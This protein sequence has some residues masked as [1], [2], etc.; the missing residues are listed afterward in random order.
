MAAAGII[1]ASML[2]DGISGDIIFET[3][4]LP[5]SNPI[6]IIRTDTNRPDI[7]SI[8]PCPNGWSVS[9]FLSAIIKPAS[10]ITDEP[11]SERLLNASAIIEIAPLML[12]A[13]NFP[14]KR[15]TFNT[16]PVI[17]VKVPYFFLTVPSE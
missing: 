17:P 14:I 5:S 9:G 11:A 4:V 7:Y 15:N 1:T 6:I 16:I 8:L 13:I 2:S 12:P 3:D 10:D